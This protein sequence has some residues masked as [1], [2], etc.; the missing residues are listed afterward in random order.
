MSEREDDLA[1]LRG[2]LDE[3]QGQLSGAQE[4]LSEAEE[5]IVWNVGTA[6]EEDLQ[7]YYDA[8]DDA[9]ARIETLEAEIAD[10]EV[11][12]ADLESANDEDDEID[13]EEIDD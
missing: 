7:E 3:L 13:F 9:V 10:V 12:I 11:S 6:P 5:D 2:R 4:R 8:Y 1:V